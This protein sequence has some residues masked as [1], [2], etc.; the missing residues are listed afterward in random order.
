L[1]K[2]AFHPPE[3]GLNGMWLPPSQEIQISTLKSTEQEHI[4]GKVWMR[5]PV[6]KI[7][8]PTE[9]TLEQGQKVV[10]IPCLFVT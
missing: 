7:L 4:L 8:K 9:V 3:G 2:K 10:P 1:I 6:L 5:I